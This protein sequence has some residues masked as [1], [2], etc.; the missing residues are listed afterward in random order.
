MTCLIYAC[1]QRVFDNW[2]KLEDGTY[3]VVVVVCPLIALMSNQV[4]SMT[5]LGLKAAYIAS[6]SVNIDDITKERI[7][8]LFCSPESLV[9]LEKQF[10]IHNINNKFTTLSV[11]RE[12][13]RQSN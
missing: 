12:L 10:R 2:L 6:T 5:K 3:I 9:K 8:L 1:L 11:T 4:K 7:Q 13:C